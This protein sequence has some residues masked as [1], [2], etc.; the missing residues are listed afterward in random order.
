MYTDKIALCAFQ[1]V[2]KQLLLELVIMRLVANEPPLSK[3]TTA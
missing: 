1:Y 3:L 2:K